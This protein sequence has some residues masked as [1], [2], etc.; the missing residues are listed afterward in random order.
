MTFLY[1]DGGRGAAGFKG[2][3]GDCVVRSIAI[4]TERPY[5]EV[6]RDIADRCK[7]AGLARSARNGVPRKVY[8]KYLLDHG[9]EWTPTMK[10]GQG[11][12]VHLR[13]DE[14]P[15]GRII[16]RLSKHMCAVVDGVV[17]DTYDC[18]REGSRCVYGYFSKGGA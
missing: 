6:Y 14:L 15:S 11:C 9:W 3:A 10:I 13:A 8:Q 5:R 1:S 12:K 16:C 2:E 18:S 4:A 17:L 7:E